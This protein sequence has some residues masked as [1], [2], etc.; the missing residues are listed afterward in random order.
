MRNVFTFMSCFF[1][2]VLEQLPA[3]ES[4]TIARQ[5][6]SI[7]D[8]RQFYKYPFSEETD[9]LIYDLHLK[10]KNRI[11]DKPADTE[12]TEAEN[13]ELTTFVLKPWI[14]PISNDFIKEP[15]KHHVRPVGNPGSDFPFIQGNFDDSNWKIVNLSH[16]WSIKGPFFEGADPEVGGGMGRLPSPG[17]AWYRKKLNIPAYDAGKSIF[18]DV[19]GT[20]SYAMVW[21]NGNLVGGWPFGYASWRV[22][23]TP[24]VVP[25]GENQLSIRLDNPPESSRWYPGGGIY[26][27]VRLTKTNPVH[28]DQWGT[29]IRMSNISEISATINLEVTIDNDANYDVTVTS[30]TEIFSIDIEGNTT[31]DPVAV[32]ESL[33]TAI[34]AGENSKVEGSITIENPRLWG[35]PPTQIPNRYV[36]VTTLWQDDKPVDQY[37]TCFG[38]RSL[39]FDPDTGIFVNGEHIQIKGVNQHHDLGA[40][41]DKVFKSIEQHPFVA[42]EFV[43]TGWDYIGE[44]TPYYESRSSYC[45]IIDLAGFKKDRFYLYQAHWRPELPM[46]HILPHWNWP[47]RVGEITPVHVFTSGDEAELFINGQSLG[48][49]KKGAFEYR[50]RWDDVK[51]EP[52]ELKVIAYKNGKKWAENSVKTTDEP[53]RLK[54]SV[55]RTKI[56]ADGIDLSFITVQVLDENGLTVPKANNLIKFEI[57]GSGEIVTTNNGDPTNFEPF[58]S[59]K[60]K[61]FSGLALAIVRL[62]A[63]QPGPIIIVAKSDGLEQAQVEI[64]AQ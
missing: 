46:V 22:N 47:D 12:P 39:H 33:E 49:K 11:D 64:K 5:R 30:V 48:R 13:V 3:P 7:N 10:I 37:E 38:I 21:L 17:V 55:Y 51:Y 1:L 36:A 8:N 14:L 63:E 4:N 54:A 31:G 19:D 40:S 32:L 42:G 24:Y 44:P 58:T 25:G 62:K 23:L 27:N 2:L 43:W 59:H 18:L 20:M 60:R 41:V 35:P 53:A 50:L 6:I 56:R 29:F 34:K 61:A 9:S 16:D 28:V 45:G 15:A 26:R 57:E 52:G